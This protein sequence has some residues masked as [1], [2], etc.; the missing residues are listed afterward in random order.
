VDE[1]PYDLYRQDAETLVAVGRALPEVATTADLPPHLADAAL[2]SWQREDTTPLA[3]AETEEQK[4]MRRDSAC[5]ALIG[6]A[7]ENARSA[8]KPAVLHLETV[9][10]AIAAAGRG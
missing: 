1:P 5:L 3:Q 2:A 10:E 7:V 9:A 8:G 4:R 6:L